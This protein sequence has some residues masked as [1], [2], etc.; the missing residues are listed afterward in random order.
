[1]SDQKPAS[2]SSG[3]NAGTPSQDFP[4]HLDDILMFKG[5][6]RSQLGAVR[7]VLTVRRLRS[8]EVLLE[9]DDQG[10]AA[11]IIHSGFVRIRTIQGDGDETTL[12]FLGPGDIVGEMS[13]VDRQTRSATVVAHE[14]VTLLVLNRA[15]FSTL[16]ERVPA[17]GLNLATVLSRRLRIANT[18]IMALATMDVEGRVAQQLLTYTREYGEQLEN[19][20]VRLPFHLTQSDIASL[21]GASRVRVNQVLGEYRRSGTIVIDSQGH[22]TIT[23]PQ[24]WIAQLER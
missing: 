4:E 3:W 16:I 12:A 15:L 18:H 1:M 13:L 17:I 6:S 2:V 9:S 5:L 14:P 23:D 7:T 21:V 10:E 20:S 24:A 22:L 19:G 11:Y 8:G